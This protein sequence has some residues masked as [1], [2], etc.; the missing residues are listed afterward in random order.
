MASEYDYRDSSSHSEILTMEHRR[1]LEPAGS[2]ADKKHDRRTRETNSKSDKQVTELLPVKRQP[3]V[4]D[5]STSVQNPTAQLN[6]HECRDYSY[7]NRHEVEDGESASILR[8]RDTTIE[9]MR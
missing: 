4:Y 9:L 7:D 5:R 6:D 1:D 8:D 3:V 2:N